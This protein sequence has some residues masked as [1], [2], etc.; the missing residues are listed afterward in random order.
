MECSR[1]RRL[2]LASTNR[3]RH[4]LLLPLHRRRQASKEYRD[5]EELPLLHVRIT[6]RAQP[7]VRPTHL[8]LERKADE[9]SPY[10]GVA[11]EFP[12]ITYTQ[13]P[14]R[15]GTT[16]PQHETPLTVDSQ[17]RS[18]HLDQAQVMLRRICLD[19]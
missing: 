7:R 8:R 14:H 6:A 1:Y 9:R 19:T 13:L 18:P 17:A 11:E 2:W 5:P 12:Q 3:L 16:E 15:L 10:L 4:Q